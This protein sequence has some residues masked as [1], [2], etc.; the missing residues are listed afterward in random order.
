MPQKVRDLLE[1]LRDAGFEEIPGAAK[2]PTENLSIQ[3][4]QVW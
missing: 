4:M 1:A 3:S 2:A